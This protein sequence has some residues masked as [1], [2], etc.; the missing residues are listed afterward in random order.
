MKS[1]FSTREFCMLW[2]RDIYHRNEIHS[3]LQAADQAIAEARFYK[4]KYFQPAQ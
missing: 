4:E 3:S 2:Q 1:N